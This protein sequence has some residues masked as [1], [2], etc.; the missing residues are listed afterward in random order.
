[1]KLDDYA[2]AIIALLI[3]FYHYLTMRTVRRTFARIANAVE[4]LANLGTSTE[5]SDQQQDSSEDD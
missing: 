1:M 4:R 2:A 3:T 5:D